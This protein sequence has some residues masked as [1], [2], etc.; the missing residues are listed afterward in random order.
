M[1]K[2]FLAPFLLVT[3]MF[4]AP[5]S[6]LD[7]FSYSGYPLK[8]SPIFESVDRMVTCQATINEMIDNLQLY[9]LMMKMEKDQQGIPMTE[10]NKWAVLRIN[11]LK[12][13]WRKI[14]DTLVAVNG[15]L[16]KTTKI[17]LRTLT[18]KQQRSYITD[19]Q[20]LVQI[21][22]AGNYLQFWNALGA[23]VV[24]CIADHQ[25]QIKPTMDKILAN[26]QEAITATPA[27]PASPL[28]PRPKTDIP[29]TE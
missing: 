24:G 18:R 5:A 15:M 29:E 12:V 1:R 17:E 10:P 27:V 7:F 9:Q 4:S 19:R 22:I 23:T 6:S 14:E 21:R 16:A 3:M 20:E 28:K 11:Q 26:V 25:A 8:F 13:D 2:Y